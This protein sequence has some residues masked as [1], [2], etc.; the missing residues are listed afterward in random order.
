MANC[1]HFIQ[2][3]YYMCRAYEPM[4]WI[5]DSQAQGLP[6]SSQTYQNSCSEEA[7]T[8]Q[9]IVYQYYPQV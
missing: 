6:N 1:Q 3:S 9:Y 7:I 2:G 5:T 8:Y 4:I